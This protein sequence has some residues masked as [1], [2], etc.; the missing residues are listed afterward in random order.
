MIA[1]DLALSGIEQ[2]K[3]SVRGG[4]RE[5]GERASWFHAGGSV[6]NNRTKADRADA[7]EIT[8]A[9]NTIS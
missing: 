5:E 4:E 9:R 7:G 2:E 8:A 3:G 1:F 6:V